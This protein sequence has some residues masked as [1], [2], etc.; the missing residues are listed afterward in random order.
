MLKSCS[1][2]NFQVK[3]FKHLPTVKL[4]WH[5]HFRM[6]LHMANAILCGIRSGTYNDNLETYR[7]LTRPTRW[8]WRDCS[9]SEATNSKS[10]E[11]QFHPLLRVNGARFERVARGGKH[12]YCAVEILR[13]P[14]R[15][16]HKSRCRSNERSSYKLPIFKRRLFVDKML[17]NCWA[18]KIE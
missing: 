17:N 6:E 18:K 9:V 13:L 4:H 15:I 7:N 3:H 10:N 14:S 12:I 2:L 16:I 5:S 8:A 11:I 1:N